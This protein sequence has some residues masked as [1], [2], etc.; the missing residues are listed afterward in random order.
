MLPFGTISME[1]GRSDV[2]RSQTPIFFQFPDRQ[3]ARNALDTLREIGYRA[4]EAE[5]EDGAAVSVFI[6]R[7]DLTSALEIAQATGGRLIERGRETGLRTFRMAY[8]T[9]AVP[10]PA[11]TVV[12]ERPDHAEK[13]DPR[14]DDKQVAREEE[15]GADGA[16][17]PS[18]DDY[19]R[20]SAG[21]TM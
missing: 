5:A 1:K 6:D 11:H 4:D 15:N 17:D 9:D 20:F 10:I 8:D 19:D 3:S 18:G 21:V 2:N 12:D 14:E 13:Q 7:N 16:I